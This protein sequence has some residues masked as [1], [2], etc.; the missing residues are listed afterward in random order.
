MRSAR[1]FSAS[2]FAA[3]VAAATVVAGIPATAAV[4]A[5]A[6]PSPAVYDGTAPTLTLQPV[7]FVLGGS[8]DQATALPEEGCTGQ[9]WNRNVPLRLRWSSTDATSRVRGFDVWQHQSGSLSKIVAD[10]TATTY[11]FPG[12]NYDGSCGGGS[13]VSVDMWV[14][15]HDNRGN[16]ATTTTRDRWIDIWQETGQDEWN[17]QELS[18]ARSGTW[19]T[20]S[21]VCFNNG[22]TLASTTRGASLT[23]TVTTDR[24][25]QTVAV[26]AA[27]NTN[28][29]V[30]NI[31]LDGA[32]ATAVNT[33]S[34][35]A[36][37][38]VIVWQKVIATP[39]THR[40]KITNA[41]TSGRPR[42]DVDA[43]MLTPEYSRE[44]PELD[45][46]M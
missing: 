1:R 45:D 18:L 38:R 34:S 44:A 36:A 14:V 41:G 37:N 23:Y 2:S 12:T 32:P 25:A 10:T 8:L 6:D 15:A 27:K 7:E 20:A 39:G 31:S 4:V 3:G 33:Y 29:G 13:L 11:A 40:I 5:L 43:I 28:R 26:V 21:C 22:R 17:Q 19:T 46:F 16:A 9:S 35:T 42:I 24:P 30:M